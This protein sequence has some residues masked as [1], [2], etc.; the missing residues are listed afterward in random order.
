[1]SS[2]SPDP[3][4]PD[5]PESPDCPRAH[6]ALATFVAGGI[7]VEEERWL[8]AHLVACEPCRDRY[9]ES[10][11][12]AAPLG[13]AKRRERIEE[14]RLRRQEAMRR[15]AL[16]VGGQRGRGRFFGLRM[17]ALV[18]VVILVLTWLNPSWNTPEFEVT[19]ETGDVRAAGTLLH[20]GVPEHTLVMGDWCLTEVASSARIETPGGELWL[21]HDTQLLVEDPKRG[22]VRLQRG[23]LEVTGRS[24][25]SSQFGIARMEEGRA[26]IDLGE[27]R[28][29]VEC[30]AGSLEW[31]HAGGSQTLV[32]GERALARD[33]G[34][35]LSVR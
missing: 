6:E 12:S 18:T 22:R 2:E 3:D 27:G 32:A 5:V 20:E 4:P 33:P 13:G 26:R 9:R 35:L 1:M 19:W 21:G 30:M 25:V 24:V 10:I 11:R 29:E 8:R 28:L 16:A 23:L 31:V 17:V 15:R 34:E 14:T 7:T